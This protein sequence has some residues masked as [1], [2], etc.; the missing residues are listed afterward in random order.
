MHLILLL[1]AV[2]IVGVTVQISSLNSIHSNQGKGPIQF[3]F[4]DT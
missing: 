3:A 2:V 1:L 4:L